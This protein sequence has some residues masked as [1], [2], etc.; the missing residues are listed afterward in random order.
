M[1]VSEREN[2]A[3]KGCVIYR[4]QIVKYRHKFLTKYYQAESTKLKKNIT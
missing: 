1:E 2:V 4:K 3:T